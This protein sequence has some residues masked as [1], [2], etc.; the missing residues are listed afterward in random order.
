MGSLA[1]KARRI[2]DDCER[3][4]PTE[5]HLDWWGRNIRICLSCRA[6]RTRAHTIDAMY[7][8]GR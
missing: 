5:D 1:D 7:K 2:C 3:E 8:G 4:Q 6:L